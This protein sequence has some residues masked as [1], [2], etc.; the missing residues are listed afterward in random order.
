M[1]SN[2]CLCCEMI[3]EDKNNATCI[4]CEKRI[5]Y[6]AHLERTLVYCPSLSEECESSVLTS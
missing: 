6:V 5:T 3:D 2:P 4:R 1:N